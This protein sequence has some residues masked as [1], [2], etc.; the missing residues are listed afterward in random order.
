[1]TNEQAL[2]RA[3]H[4]CNVKGVPVDGIDVVKLAEHLKAHGDSAVLKAVKVAKVKGISIH[5]GQLLEMAKF[6]S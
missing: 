1:M 5:G 3:A 4:I 2:K 6:L